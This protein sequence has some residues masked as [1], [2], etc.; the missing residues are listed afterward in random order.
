MIKVTNIP[1]FNHSCLVQL[2]TTVGVVELYKNYPIMYGM[3]IWLFRHY[4]N[5]KLYN[6][7][8]CIYF[9][10]AGTEEEEQKEEHIAI[11]D[12]CELFCQS[13]MY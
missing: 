12:I 10:G 8:D 1:I 5:K 6:I 4:E 7:S 13:E 3:W 11:R 9:R 2:F